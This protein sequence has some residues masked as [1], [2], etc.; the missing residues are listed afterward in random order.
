MSSTPIRFIVRPSLRAMWSSASTM[1]VCCHGQFAALPNAIRLS[2]T[3][4]SSNARHF[5]SSHRPHAAASSSVSAS[6][7][8]SAPAPAD[9]TDDPAASVYRSIHA[10]LTETL[11]PTYLNVEDT[12]GGCGSFFR[13]LIASPHFDGVPLVRQHRMVKEAIKADIGR[14]HGL[15]IDTMTVQQYAE[16]K[17]AADERRKAPIS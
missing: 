13:L 8:A 11:Q 10:K 6:A 17:K 4:F 1:S 14:I 5:T 16:R 3:R 15:T 12:S 7:S 2:S 9:A